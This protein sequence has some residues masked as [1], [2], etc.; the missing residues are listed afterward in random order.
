MIIIIIRD[1]WLSKYYFDIKIIWRRGE[2]GR[3]FPDYFEISGNTNFHKFSEFFA[4]GKFFSIKLKLYKL[5]I[6][7]NFCGAPQAR[8]FLGRFFLCVCT[9]FL[10]FFQGAFFAVPQ[11]LRLFLWVGFFGGYFLRQFFEVFFVAPQFFCV[12]TGFFLRVFFETIFWGRFCV[13]FE[14]V[15]GPPQARN[16]FRGY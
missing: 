5:K 3:W 15:F 11:F 12:C 14:G 13:C 4:V 8:F 16:F 2:G 6:N 9:R 1:G 7:D 10:H